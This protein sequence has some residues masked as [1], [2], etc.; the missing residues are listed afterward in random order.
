[1]TGYFVKDARVPLK[2]QLA[3]DECHKRIQVLDDL[4]L[5]AA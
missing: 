4:R 2:P 5:L 1:M 3:R